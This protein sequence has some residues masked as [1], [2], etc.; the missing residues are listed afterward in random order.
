MTTSDDRDM[1]VKVPRT[2][3]EL[4]DALVNEAR[5]EWVPN[6][7]SDDHEQRLLARIAAAEAD[8]R[9]RLVRGSGSG[10]WA[11]LAAITAVAAGVAFF[12]H[13]HG[14]DV[15]SSDGD[16]VAVRAAPAPASLMPIT[17]AGVVRVDGVAVRAASLREGQK[18][19]S[20]GGVANFVAP[21]RVDWVLESG[22]VVAVE[23]SGGHGGAIVLGLAMGAV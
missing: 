8:T 10:I 6:S 7:V 15:S 5:A 13:P 21:G 2:D 22:T 11:P 16:T 14:G 18:V 12:M 1:K 3:S 17:G 19:E 20:E 4:V 9:L 23:R